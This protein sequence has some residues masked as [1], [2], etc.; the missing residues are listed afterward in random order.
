[1]LVLAQNCS[2]RKEFLFAT[3][4]VNSLSC[5]QQSLREREKANLVILGAFPHKILIN[6]SF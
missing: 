3:S 5:L 2:G 1:M 4:G 6:V